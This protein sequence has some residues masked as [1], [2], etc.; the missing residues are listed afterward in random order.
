MADQD[1]KTA[2]TRRQCLAGSAVAAL[3]ATTP[4]LA[5]TK[6]DGR[7]VG[8]PGHRREAPAF[9]RMTLDK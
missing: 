7:L 2:I 1:D 3:A 5:E 9:R 8:P 6:I 4:A